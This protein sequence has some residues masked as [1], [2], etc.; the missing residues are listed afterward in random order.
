M[1][2][3]LYEA[4]N[5]G[6]TAAG[7]T[8]A[9][10]T[11]VAGGTAA[12][13][14]DTSCVADFTSR[15]NTIKQAKTTQDSDVQGLEAAIV[16]INGLFGELMSSGTGTVDYVSKVDTITRHLSTVNTILSSYKTNIVDPLNTLLT[17]VSSKLNV[18]NRTRMLGELLTQS[19]SAE[20]ELI[21]ATENLST[22]HTREAVLD[23]KED[24][25]SYTQAWGYIARP[26][27]RNTIPILI[28]FTLLFFGIGVVGLWFVSP[29]SAAAQ[30]IAAG[31]VGFFQHPA[32][33]MT[34]VMVVV[35]GLILGALKLGKQI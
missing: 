16:A 2:S 5:V 8:A 35:V 15:L 13:G 6:G 25:I 29:Y 23:T 30:S 11:T 33:W 17:E 28:V 24:A 31:E 4:F 9:G 7:G 1:P 20:S 14:C 3:I 27:K 32:V 26:L 12:T 22:A 21:E 34:G 19:A 10:G 18:N